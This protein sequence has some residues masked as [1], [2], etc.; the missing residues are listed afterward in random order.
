MVQAGGVVGR[1]E[2][3]DTNGAS[4]KLAD[5]RLLIGCF[6]Q[7]NTQVHQTLIRPAD[8]CCN[9]CAMM[10][11][12]RGPVSEER[13]QHEYSVTNNVAGECIFVS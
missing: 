6:Q 10:S 13:V 1:G 2:P 5:Q 12:R 8:G 11:Y 9:S 4:F 3:H 7:D